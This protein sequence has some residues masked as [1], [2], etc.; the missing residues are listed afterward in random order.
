MVNPLAAMFALGFVVAGFVL[1]IIE[2]R[3]SKFL[4]LQQVCGLDRLSYWLSNFT[5]D[6]ISYVAISVVI[7]VMYAIAQ[8]ENFSGAGKQGTIL[9]QQLLVHQPLLQLLLL[10]CNSF[11]RYPLLNVL[12]VPGV[13]CVHDP[14]D[15][16]LL[17]SV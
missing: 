15:V 1:A 9:I 11:I 5:W 12:L 13:R 10:V 14:L 7:L 3:S 17:L 2:E 6:F 16:R 4:H 8:D